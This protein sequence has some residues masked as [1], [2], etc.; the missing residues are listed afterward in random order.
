MTTAAIDNAAT[1]AVATMTRGDG[2][3]MTIN[4]NTYKRSLDSALTAMKMTVI[5]E[6]GIIVD[7]Y[8]P[9][10]AL[11]PKE[12]AKFLRERLGMK[13]GDP[14]AYVAEIHQERLDKLEEAKASLFSLAPPYLQSS[15]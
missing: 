7:H 12:L 1:M 8:F 2:V 10:Q 6:V 14:I 11:P 13:R 15:A 5:A 3:Y 9:T 4:E